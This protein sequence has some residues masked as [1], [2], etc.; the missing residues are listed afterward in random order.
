MILSM[1]KGK[2]KTILG[3]AIGVI[4]GGLIGGLR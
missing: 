4:G 2:V 1:Y 3:T